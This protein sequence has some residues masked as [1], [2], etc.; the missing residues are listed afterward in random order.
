MTRLHHRRASRTWLDRFPLGNGRIGAMVGAA[1]GALR[2]GLNESTV[3][4]G[5]PESQTRDL[6]A[7]EVA[8][9]A[10]ARAEALFDAGDPV[11]AEAAL[12]PLQHSW[13]QTF[14][15]VGELVVE[16]GDDVD[17]VERTLD[18]AAAL[19][20]TLQRGA[21]RTC[22]S[23]T[24]TLREADLLLHETRLG[25]RPGGVR[26]RFETPLRVREATTDAAGLTRVLDVPADAAP[27]HEPTQP[28]RTWEVPGVTTLAVAVALRIHH[29]GRARVVD[30]GI[31]VLDATHLRLVLA[32]ETN[33]ERV[34]AAPR[35]VAAAVARAAERAAL[36]LPGD[37]LDLHAA[38]ERTASGAVVL[39]TPSSVA[40][41]EPEWLVARGE[42]AALLPVLFEHGRYLLRA[43]SRPG[44]PPANLQGL[45][46]AELQPPWSSNYTLNIN[47]PMNY[48]GAEP[49]GTGDAHRALL[50]LLEG[51]VERGRDAAR[52]LYGAGG[53]V[54]HHNSDP[55][56]HPWPTRGDA[57]WAIWPMGGAWL[58]R[59]FDEHRRFGSMTPTTLARFWPVARGA[60]E[61]LLDFA[62]RPDG[63]VA[64]FPS[65]SPEN[66][67][68]VGDAAAALTRS[69]ALDMAL[70]REVLELVAEL[71]TAVGEPADP[72]AARCRELL[73]RVPAPARTREGTV[74]EWGSDVAA[75]DPQHRHVSHL[76]GWFPGS[77]GDDGDH[78]AVRRTLDERG[79]DSTGW[80]LAWKL[81][82]AARLRDV[83]R[84]ER[85]LPLAVRV[86]DEG[87][88]QRG[89]LYPNLFAAHPPFQVDGNL[90]LLGAVC[91][92]LV[93]SHR[94]GRIDLLPTLPAALATG[95]VTGLVARPGIVV[96][97]DW[98]AGT[99]NRAVLTA[100]TPAAAGGIE[101]TTP[102]RRALVEV[103]HGA[104]LVLDGALRTIPGP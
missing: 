95:S 56:A 6:V 79:D 18:L 38:A 45:W 75:V 14:L 86:A 30:D 35:P 88:G 23:R 40:E 34:G 50:E 77:S 94:P 57:S 49:T 27:A 48:W 25:P 64:T 87:F 24:A 89:G 46:N 60:A 7:D 70:L 66:H 91:E 43:A 32:V 100:R 21:A 67:Y 90:G 52:R 80:S 78:D 26:I 98:T 39:A 3:W 37:A 96:D 102:H 28:A 11:A 10:L 99:L 29:D 69:S 41:V 51:L 16:L 82:L 97:L 9:A 15:P 17:E 53:W 93:Q 68:R 74:L 42:V 73:P 12:Q 76:F 5:G 92:L 19:H 63:T 62:T 103:P 71:A 83:E 20:T 81:G 61:F 36:A 33:F 101:L 31:E 44:L 65:T 8:A 2:I 54:A 104:P 85:L 84:V 1:G 4:S 13:A 55:W 47:T 72:V 22:T 59:Q 58:V